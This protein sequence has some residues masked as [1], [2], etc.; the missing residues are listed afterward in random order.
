MLDYSEPMTC[1]YC[2]DSVIFT[3]HTA[4]GFDTDYLHSNMIRR[5]LP[6]KTGKPYGLEADI[7][8]DEERPK[9]VLK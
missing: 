4:K 8:T 3:G 2:G 5:C 9:G 7:L 1:K 6:A